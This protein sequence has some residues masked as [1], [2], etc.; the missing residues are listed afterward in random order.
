MTAYYLPEQLQQEFEQA[1]Q[2]LFASGGVTK[3]LSEAVELW[4]TQNRKKLI[5]I[6]SIANN[7]AFESLKSEFEKKYI[8]KWIMIAHGT[9]QGVADLPEQLNHLAPSAH[10][11][12]VA[13][14]GQTQTKEVELGWQMAFA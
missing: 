1:A 5:Q 6:E 12:L 7:N 4:L 9:L 8:G 3:A 10:H 13:Q 11:R 2:A 14:I